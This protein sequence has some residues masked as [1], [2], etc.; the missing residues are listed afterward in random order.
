MR[1]IRT[2]NGIYLFPKG[3]KKWETEKHLYLVNE[4][5]EL[6]GCGT[7]I[8]AQADT[9]EELCDELVIKYDNDEKPRTVNMTALLESCSILGLAFKGHIKWLYEN[10]KENLE[11]CCLSIWVGAKLIP[12]AKLNKEGELELI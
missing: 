6:W 10:Y 5:N 4:E 3:F 8:I 2:T 1:Y 7:P 12:V 9:I 11:I